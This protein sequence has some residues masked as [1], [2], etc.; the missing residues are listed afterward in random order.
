M[1]N[2]V[3]ILDDAS[4]FQRGNNWGWLTGL[5]FCM[6]MLALKKDNNLNVPMYVRGLQQ[7]WYGLL[8]N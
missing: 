7:F 4:I 3:E 1:A 2:F 8:I 5:G 6:D